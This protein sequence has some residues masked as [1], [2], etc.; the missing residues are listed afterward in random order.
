V[1]GES[2]KG[3]LMTKV[4]F[5]KNEKERKAKQWL[6]RAAV[7]QT[8]VRNVFDTEYASHRTL[9]SR[10]YFKPNGGALGEICFW[11]T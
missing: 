5:E 7:G 2:R 6:T 10:L 4:V 1:A 3:I 9:S 11:G 8:D